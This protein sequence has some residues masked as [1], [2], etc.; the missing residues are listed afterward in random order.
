MRAGG[1]HGNPTLSRGVPHL[2]EDRL[3]VVDVVDSHHDLGGAAERERAAGRIVV[4]G[5]DVEHVLGPSEPG[6]GTPPQLDD[7]CAQT[8]G[9]Q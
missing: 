8:P 3:V 1:N 5:G 2:L 6:G 4:R 7:A 9:G